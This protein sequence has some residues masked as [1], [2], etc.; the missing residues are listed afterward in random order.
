MDIISQ[1][2][3]FVSEHILLTLVVAFFCF[4]TFFMK[5]ASGKFE[6][7]PG[8]KVIECKTRDEFQE[9]IQAAAIAKKLVVIDFF[10]VWCGPC[11]YAAPSY[12]KMSIGQFHVSSSCC[13]IFLHF[14]LLHRLRRCRFPEGGCR[15]QQPSC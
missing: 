4:R 3:Q 12:G 7:Y 10:A 13:L 1:V 11:R 2:V 9:Q 14:Q 15:C 6:E 8:N 5:G